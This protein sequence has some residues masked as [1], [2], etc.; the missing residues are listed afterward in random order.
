MTFRRTA[1]TAA[2]LSVY[3]LP[4]VGRAQSSETEQPDAPTPSSAL[5]QLMPIDVAGDR[6][7]GYKA[8]SLQSPKYVMPV[9]DTPQ[10]VTIITEQVLRDTA[11]TSLEDAVRQVPGITFLAGE[12]GQPIADRPVIRGLNSTANVFV[13]GVRDIGDQSRDVFDLEAVEVVKGADSVY[14]GRGSGGGSINLVSKTA[15]AEDFT[16]ASF[17]VGTAN[18]FRGTVDQNWKIGEDAGFRLGVLGESSGVPGRND[19]V[20]YDKFGISPSLSFGIGAASRITLDYYHLRDKG[21][22]DYSIPYDLATGLPATETLD[23]DRDNFYGLIDRDFRDAKTDIGT[24]IV[25]HEFNDSLRLRNVS[26]IGQSSNDY[27]VTNPDDSRGN[28]ANGLVYRSVKQRSS[29]TDTYANQIDLSGEFSTGQFIHNFDIGLE[30]SREKRRADGYSVTSAAAAFGSNCSS[31][32]VDPA[33]GLTF[34]QLL[35][36]NGDC[37][38]LYDPEPYDDWDGSVS[39][40]DDPIIYQTDVAAL[41]GFDTVELNEHWLVS[42]GLRLDHYKSEAEQASVDD[43]RIHSSDSFANYQLGLVYKP[44]ENGSIYLSHGTSTTPA[45]LAGGDSDAPAGA[46]NGRRGFSPDNTN[47]EPEETTSYEIG[48]KWELFDSRLLLT[49]A[50]FQLNR[51]NAYIQVGADDQDFA[52]AGETRVRGVELSV[53][54]R[55]TD[56]WQVIGGYSYLDSELIEGGFESLAEGRQLPNVPEHS[57]TLFTHYAITPT[58]TLGGGASYVD[59]VFGS[60]TSTPPKR[61][62]DYVR[63]DADAAWQVSDSTRLRLNVLNLTDETYYTRAYSSHYAALGPG[64]Q[65]LLSADLFFD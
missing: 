25:E 61:V 20:E 43:A 3:A 37:T 46:S 21:M 12:G 53:S 63:F 38:S 2:I 23:V 36:N 22:P 50:V 18:K 11:A 30:L 27:V 17:T 41:Y 10:S 47:L 64:R 28:V 48:T 55:L 52:Y 29:E 16:Q 39:R 49:A 54:G 44:R 34:G 35:Q 19:A 40:V 31:D 13:D 24:V 26:R 14:A 6:V 51:D 65:Y 59:E 56:R 9:R 62:P 33:T 60:V 4:G 57:A 1:L 42:A 58:L 8:D 7:N 45:P 32:E 15:R 5:A